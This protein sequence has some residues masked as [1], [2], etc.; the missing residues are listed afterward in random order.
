MSFSENLFLDVS[1]CNFEI[2][3]KT[4]SFLGGGGAVPCYRHRHENIILPSIEYC[5]LPRVTDYP[6]ST[7]LLIRP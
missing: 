7:I 4:C 6:R 1:T 3:H 2:V 5:I